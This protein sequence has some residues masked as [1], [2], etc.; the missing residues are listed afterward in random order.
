MGDKIT[1][2]TGDMEVCVF[3]WICLFVYVCVCVCGWG[4][5]G[6]GIKGKKEKKEKKEKKR[7]KNP[8]FF[9]PPPLFSILKVISP[10]SRFIHSMLFEI[11]NAILL[12]DRS[13]VSQMEFL[14]SYSTGD[15]A[16][17]RTETTVSKRNSG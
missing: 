14:Y 17:K 9:P 4:G 13:L 3:F 16:K 8:I 12:A 2:G 15:Y 6:G 5:G 1:K 10:A 7:K 11:S